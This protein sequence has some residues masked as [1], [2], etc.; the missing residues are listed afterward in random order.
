MEK[1]TFTVK[2][3]FVNAG[4]K[5]EYEVFQSQKIG[6]T[7][8]HLLHRNFGINKWIVAQGVEE[9][10]QWDRGYYFEHYKDAEDLFSKILTT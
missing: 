4:T 7:N 5:E 2:S 8:V 6:S 3:I 1:V 9:D 10:G